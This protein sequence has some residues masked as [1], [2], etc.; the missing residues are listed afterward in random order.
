[1]TTANVDDRKPISEIV[2]EFYG[3]LYGDKGYISSPLEQELADKEV[4][5]TTT[6]EKNMKPKV[7]KL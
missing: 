2:D 7:M 5:L 1:M 4:T 3:C 6:V